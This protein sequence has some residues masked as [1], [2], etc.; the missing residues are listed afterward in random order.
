MAAVSV[1]GGKH[2]S[3]G[4]AGDGAFVVAILEC[5]ALIESLQSLRPFARDGSEVATGGQ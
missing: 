3:V 1:D 5:L 4:G 2:V